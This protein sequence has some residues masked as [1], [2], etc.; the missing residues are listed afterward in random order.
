MNNR[1]RISRIAVYKLCKYSSSDNRTS[2]KTKLD[3][4]LK[5]LQKVGDRRFNTSTPEDP[6]YH[7]VSSYHNSKPNES[8]FT[9]GTLMTYTPGKDTLFIIDDDQAPD[10]LLEQLTAEV[11]KEGKR[12][13]FLESLIYF[14]VKGNHISL[15]QSQHLKS[16]HLCRYMTWLLKQAGEIHQSDSLVF[17][18]TPPPH[19]QER[20]K[21]AKGV[22]SI[23]FTSMSNA[24]EQKESCGTLDLFPTDPKKEGNFIQRM[25]HAF[26]EESRSSKINFS[27]LFDS[28]IKVGMT[29]DLDR[30]TSDGGQKLMDEIGALLRS[31]EDI[32]AILELKDG[33][34]IRGSMLRLTYP[35]RLNS[36]GGQL[37][38]S[39]VYGELKKWLISVLERKLSN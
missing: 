7:I 29:F 19:E 37:I 26:V 15:I 23:Q 27:A 12:R 5:T 2:L 13:E 1:K 14:C 18:D 3:R 24:S 17:L 36:Y 8:G 30:D 32:D 16:D 10:V 33:G 21:L 31:T 22:K 39:E 6:C 9:F 25:L 34:T 20:L 35:I 28:R 38:A 4:A 11:T